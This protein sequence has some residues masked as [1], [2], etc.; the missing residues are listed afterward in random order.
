MVGAQGLEPS[1]IG[2]LC[3]VKSTRDIATSPS[4]WIHPTG[5]APRARW[6]VFAMYTFGQPKRLN[7]EI[8]ASFPLL[9][10]CFDGR[11]S[12]NRRSFAFL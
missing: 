6:C 9:P 5:F 1:E 2:S 11:L 12:P 10:A 3:S 7:R 8:P 4:C